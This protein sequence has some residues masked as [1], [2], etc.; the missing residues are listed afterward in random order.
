M[1]M[2]SLQTILKIVKDVN[3]LLFFL[4]FYSR[5]WRAKKKEEEKASI[6]NYQFVVLP[7]NLILTAALCV[8][9]TVLL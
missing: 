5:S 9:S 8:G 6:A 2:T 4:T 1:V 3:S 7:I